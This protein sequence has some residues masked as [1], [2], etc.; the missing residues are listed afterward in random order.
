[1]LTWNG[2]R[3]KPADEQQKNLL[4]KQ[5]SA[6]SSDLILT[7]EMRWPADRQTKLAGFW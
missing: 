4:I 5:S 7:I 6:Q 3:S 1:M 2:K